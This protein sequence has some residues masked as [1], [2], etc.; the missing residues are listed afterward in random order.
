MK[1]LRWYDNYSSLQKLLG[2]LENLPPQHLQTV[3]NDI[4]QIIF[5]EIGQPIENS[6]ND[7]DNAKNY[8][9]NRWYDR[10]PELSNSL[11]VIKHLP[12]DKLD[13]VVSKIFEAVY[14]VCLEDYNEF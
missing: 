12:E 7:I 8:P 1:Y 3:A 2:F 9:Q 10:Y 11:E 5:T 4:I 13:F 6:M 14:Y